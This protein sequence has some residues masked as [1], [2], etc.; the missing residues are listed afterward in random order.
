MG[1][2]ISR[3]SCSSFSNFNR[4][5]SLGQK[6]VGPR[7]HFFQADHQKNNSFQLAVGHFLLSKRVM[8]ALVERA[9]RFELATSSLGSLHSTPEL[10]P[11]DNPKSSYPNHQNLSIFFRNC[12]ASRRVRTWPDISA[13]PSLSRSH[14]TNSPWGIPRL[15]M[16]CLPVSRGL[17]GRR[18]NSS[19]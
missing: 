3:T 2:M 11:P 7:A 1:S 16:I 19:K 8:I 4:I 18:A 13:S 6:K 5:F 12:R 15:S 17:A 14:P 10:R 9:T